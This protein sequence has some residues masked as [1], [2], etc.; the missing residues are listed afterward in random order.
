MSDAMIQI[1]VA[2]VHAEK[3][4][5]MVLDDL[6]RIQAEKLYGI[7]DA[8]VV[9]RDK[10]GELHVWERKDWDSARGGVAGL[11]VGASVGL[12]AGP[13]AVLV[14]AAGAG[15]GALAAKLRDSG[16]DDARLKEL[17]ESLAPGSS[18]LVA[19]LE[20]EHVAEYESQ[21]AQLGAETI[22]DQVPAEIAEGLLRDGELS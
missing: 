21:L 14:G 1:V 22:R 6:D 18:A 7:R 11:L 19:V 2:V 15:I 8:A 10:G 12:I 20:E 17:G 3:D 5:D 9:R 13:G 4:A 16:F